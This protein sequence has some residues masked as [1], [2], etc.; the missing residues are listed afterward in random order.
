MS[1]VQAVPGPAVVRVPGVGG[2][3]HRDATLRRGRRLDDQRELP[4]TGPHV[5]QA[6]L[7]GRRDHEA[8]GAGPVEIVAVDLREP[9]AVTAIGPRPRRRSRDAARA[10]VDEGQVVAVP[11]RV[12]E[13]LAVAL[14]EVPLRY[15]TGEDAGI[16]RRVIGSLGE[17]LPDLELGQDPVIDGRR[18]DLAVEDLGRR[19]AASI[20][21]DAHGFGRVED[22]A[23]ARGGH[24]Q[25]PVDVDALVLAVVGR[26][27]VRP[28][29]GGDRIGRQR[30][31]GLVERPGGA[32]IERQPSARHEVDV[33]GGVVRGGVLREDAVETAAAG[34]D[35]PHPR[36]QRE[37]AR[38]LQRRVGGDRGVGARRRAHRGNVER[39]FL[40]E[41]RVLV[42]VVRAPHGDGSGVGADV[43]AHR[44]SRP[45]A[46]SVEVGI[47]GEAGR[48]ADQE[49]ERCRGTR[50][51]LHVYP[52][53]SIAAQYSHI[54]P[55]DRRLP[56]SLEELVTPDESGQTYG[57]SGRSWTTRWATADPVR[58]GNVGR[59]RRHP[60]RRWVEFRF[61]CRA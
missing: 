11:G 2:R 53:H 23:R 61:P 6:T 36:F 30:A 31:V 46:E 49:H 39:A 52:L 19:A 28:R 41:L 60:C 50:G 25:I 58:R 33:V 12:G 47:L 51:G 24:V 55:M 17:A 34:V 26:D 43:H 29:V 59:T 45:G 56:E 54:T 37:S 8:E 57:S 14:V 38:D 9:D 42:E 18:V 44:L 13:G 35:R 10:V 7:P 20:G 32:E 16:A 22:R 40:E 3:E 21:A 48:R 27:H 4:R 5:V 1:R 15:R